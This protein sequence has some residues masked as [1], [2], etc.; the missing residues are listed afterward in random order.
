MSFWFIYKFD[1]FG[2]IKDSFNNK[3][4]P[5]LIDSNIY[6]MYLSYLKFDIPIY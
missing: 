3:P 1:D 5:T 2:F 4:L 6:V